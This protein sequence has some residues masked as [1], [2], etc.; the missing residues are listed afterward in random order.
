MIPCR[1]LI[2]VVYGLVILKEQNWIELN[3]LEYGSKDRLEL[4][5]CYDDN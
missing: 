1:V 5:L 4:V 3:C 2:R